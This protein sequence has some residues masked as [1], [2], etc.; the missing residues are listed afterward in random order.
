MAF[1]NVGVATLPPE[2]AV[3]TQRAQVVLTGLASG[4]CH[5]RA[6]PGGLWRLL[7]VIHGHSGYW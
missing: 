2:E 6:I 4:A 1:L 3:I 7:A 5:L